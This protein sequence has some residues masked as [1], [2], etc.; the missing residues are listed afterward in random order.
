MN[1][2]RASA[3]LAHLALNPQQPFTIDVEAI[4][5]DLYRQSVYWALCALAHGQGAP[6]ASDAKAIWDSTTPAQLLKAADTPEKLESLRTALHDGSFVYFAELEE[7][8]RPFV[9]SELRKLAAALLLELG[10]KQSVLAAIRRRRMVSVAVL[11]AVL[12]SAICLPVWAWKERQAREDLT[13]G[14]T[15]TASSE[16]G[17]GCKS[18][19]QRCLEY[20]GFFF[21]T[22]IS[23]PNPWV[24]FD[25]G[26]AKQVSRVLVDNRSDCCIERVV[27]LIIELSEDHKN[28]RTV[29]EQREAFWTWPASFPRQTA[30]WVRLRIPHAGTLHLARVRIER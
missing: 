2:A 24:E 27:P 22:V 26:G 1:R 17:L 23:D 28:Y 19:E 4:A 3:D 18:P 11:I 25:L 7:N 15:W 10:D 6:A 5:S 16:L 13:T 20:D 21:H 30:R 8:E 14:R 12:G 9:T 29:A